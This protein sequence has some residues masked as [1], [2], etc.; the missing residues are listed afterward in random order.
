ME[1]R[2]CQI[3]SEFYADPENRYIN[4]NLPSKKALTQRIQRTRIKNNEKLPPEP[5]SLNF[6]YDRIFCSLDNEFIVLADWYDHSSQERVSIFSTARMFNFICDSEIWLADGTFQTCP[7]LFYQMLIIHGNLAE[8]RY[9]SYPMIFILMSGKSARLY[10]K[11]LEMLK[12]VA[13]NRGKRLHLTHALFDFEKAVSGSF[14][15]AF[16]NVNF[17]GCLFHFDQIIINR[18]KAY[19]LYRDFLRDHS[20][21][22][23][24]SCLMSLAYLPPDEIPFYFD[25]LYSTLSLKAKQIASWLEINYIKGQNENPPRYHPTFWSIN[26]NFCSG[27]PT[28]QNWAESYHHRLHSILDTE[29]QPIYKFLQFLKKEFIAIEVDIDKFL[30]GKPQKHRMPGFERTENALKAILN[31]RQSIARVETLKA[32]VNVKNDFRQ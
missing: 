11:A 9:V 6:E 15:K 19:K 7:K 20:F 8:D 3:I 22:V 13:R 21:Y 25:D 23:E 12:Q 24:I 29:R 5:L 16:P 2:P 10:D 30:S 31:R 4:A 1:S 26:G 28:T 14:I 32:I 17:S 27:Y 18:V